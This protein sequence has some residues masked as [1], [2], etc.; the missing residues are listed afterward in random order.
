MGFSIKME[1]QSDPELMQVMRSA[2]QECASLA[3]FNAE[4][5]RM[6]TLA[7]D[8]ALTNIIRHAYGNRHDQTI[9]MTC[10]RNDREL[11]FILED[12]GKP[13][14]LAKIRSKPLGEVRPGG[15]GTHIM[16]KV[17]DVVEYEPSPDGNRVRLVKFREQLKAGG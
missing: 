6:I 5:C 9:H 4:D 14:D 15:L 1:L 10:N 16:A 17:M 8:E 7:V 13:A 11:E 3:D 12:S 2:V